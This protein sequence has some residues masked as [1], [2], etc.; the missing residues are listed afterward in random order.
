MGGSISREYFLYLFFG[1]LTTLISIASYLIFYEWLGLPNVHSNVL[2]WVLAVSFVFFT[3]KLWVFGSRSFAPFIFIS[4]L[5]RFFGARLSTGVLE[6]AF[7]YIGVDLLALPAVPL[8][9]IVTVVV[10]ILNYVLSKYGVF[11]KGRA[12]F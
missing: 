12:D 4:E 2:S 3:N 8:K 6:L 11:R 10:I 9:V 1:G 7:M 5:V